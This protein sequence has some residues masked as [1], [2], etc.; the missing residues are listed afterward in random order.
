[1]AD[2]VEYATAEKF[3]NKIV[4]CQM[5]SLNSI[6]ANTASVLVFASNLTTAPRVIRV[7]AHGIYAN[8]IN[9]IFSAPFDNGT[10]NFKANGLCYSS[11]GKW[12]VRMSLLSN[13]DLTDVYATAWYTKD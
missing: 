12:A 9:N 10:Q 11:G 3:N 6:A 5:K 13:I 8:N 7:S 4:Y 1:M 2:G